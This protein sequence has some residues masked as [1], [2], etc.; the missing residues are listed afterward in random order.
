M[1]IR[2]SYDGTISRTTNLKSLDHEISKILIRSKFPS[3]GEDIKFVT[4]SHD[5]VDSF[6]HPYW[7]QEE[8]VVYLDARGYSTVT[9]DGTVSYR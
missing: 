8:D 7:R 9:A 5:D 4:D 1:S 6:I 2:H 3:E